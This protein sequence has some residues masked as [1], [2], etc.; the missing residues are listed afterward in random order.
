M[1]SQEMLAI[2]RLPFNG[3]HPA[4]ADVEDVHHELTVLKKV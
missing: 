1:R 4:S 2:K 3:A